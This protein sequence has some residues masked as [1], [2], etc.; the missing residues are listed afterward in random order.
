M[1]LVQTEEKNVVSVILQFVSMLLV[2]DCMK[3]IRMSM[4]VIMLI[5]NK[6]K[7]ECK[8]DNIVS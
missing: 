3:T 4:L 2:L 6:M 5:K 8:Y 7:L 1:S